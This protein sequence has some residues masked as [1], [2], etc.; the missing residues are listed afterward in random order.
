MTTI[1]FEAVPAVQTRQR[2]P[3]LVVMKFGGTSV[4]D[5]DKLKRVAGTGSCNLNPVRSGKC[6]WAPILLVELA[7]HFGQCLPLI[8]L[9]ALLE[10]L[11]ISLPKGAA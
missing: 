6:H 10:D 2:T 7:V 5:T 9:G 4:G 3:G 8:H 11:R 1:D